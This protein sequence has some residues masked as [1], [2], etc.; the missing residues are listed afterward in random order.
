MYVHCTANANV[1]KYIDLIVI[2]ESVRTVLVSAIYFHFF[3]PIIASER[4][5][6]EKSA[7]N[8]SHAH[9]SDRK[10]W[11]IDTRLCLR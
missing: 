6:W 4:E 2:D 8:D 7:E 10:P 3:M 9:T 11:K 1:W 5:T